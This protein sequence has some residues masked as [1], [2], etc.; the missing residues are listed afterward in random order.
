V[1]KYIPDLNFRRIYDSF[2]SPVTTID[3][4]QKCA[5][6]N[7]NGKPICCDICEAVPAAYHIE[8]QFLQKNT[9]LWHEW[10]GGE[11]KSDPEDP[12][13]L[14]SEAPEH[15]TLLACLGP[16]FCQRNYRAVSC[17]QFPFIPYVTADYRFLGLTYEWQFETTC[18]VINNL[19]Q[20]TAT[21]KREFITLFDELFALWQEEFDSY[22]ILSEQMRDHFLKIK[23]RIPI[24][25][26]NGGYYLLS[27]GSEQIAR[28][29][30]D[31]FK[32]FAPY[33]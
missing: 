33:K 21:Y 28:I 5:P 14:L 23:R 8:W 10:Q 12:S 24:L 31:Q 29:K 2:D 25:H 32:K 19:D 13:I 7:K 1:N 6:H 9:K 4:G 22:A 20:V 11:C 15:Q 17:R 18:W 30:P 16:A 27:P 26:R 3:C